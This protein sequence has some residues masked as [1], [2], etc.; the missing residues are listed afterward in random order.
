MSAGPRGSDEA[1]LTRISRGDRAALELL[2]REHAHW[3]T[4]R[5]HRRCNDPDIVDLA[6]QDTFLAVWKS[7]KKYKGTGEVGAWIWGIAVR[8][9]IDQL[10]K[11][12]PIPVDPHIEQPQ[13]AT[14]GSE[15]EL[16]S[17]GV[18]GD[19]GDALRA[20]DPDLQRVL[21]A[22]AVDGLTTREAGHLL[23]IPQGTVKTRLKRARAQLQET[24]R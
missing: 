14:T 20:L 21:L 2:Y 16:L 5:L 22:T 8:R 7:A 24:L 11:R 17:S 6:V 1:L 23:G 10:R 9:L 15:E 18:Y 19:V 12:K 13:V 3:V 4:A